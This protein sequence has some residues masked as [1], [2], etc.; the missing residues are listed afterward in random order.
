MA[1]I[2]WDWNENRSRFR[3]LVVDLTIHNDI[4]SFLGDHGVY[5]ILGQGYISEEGYYFGIQTDVSDPSIGRSRGKGLIYSRWGTRDL[6]N[7]RIPEDGWTESSGHEG[8]FIGVR[9]AYDW[10]AGDYRLRLAPDGTDEDGEWFSLWITDLGADTTTWVGALQFPFVNGEAFI[11]PPSY[12]T[13]EIYG[14]RKIRPID[15]PELSISVEPPLGDGGRATHGWTNYSPFNGEI[16]NSEVRC[17]RL[18]G[19]V[20]LKAGG[21][22]ERETPGDRWVY[23]PG[24]GRCQY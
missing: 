1:N 16:L 10:T 5:L 11:Q 6:A 2:W 19:T 21:L 3:E 18:T 17:D 4:D 9:R 7:A 22:T 12:T 15:I 14:G 13:I 23:F 8:D 20:F 24:P